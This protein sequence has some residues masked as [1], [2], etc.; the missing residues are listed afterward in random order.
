MVHGFQDFT[1]RTTAYTNRDDLKWK[2]K[3]VVTYAMPL[4]PSK[5]QIS[6]NIFLV[7]LYMSN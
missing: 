3:F 6:E 1:R 5:M 7:H 4:K 2:Y